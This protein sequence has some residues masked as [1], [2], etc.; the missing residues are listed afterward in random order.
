MSINLDQIES[1]SLAGKNA[2][3]KDAN[4]EKW[5]EKDIQLFGSGLGDRKKEAFYS[6]L[7]VL[8]SAGVDI[9]SAL[10]L[11]EEE[12]R[13]DRDKK[14][15]QA[16]G[17]SVMSGESLS[18]AIRSSGSFSDYEYF[19][20]RIGEESGRLPEVLQDLARYYNK[21]LA[22]RR[23]V[24]NAL[25]YPIIV[26]LTAVGAIVFML[27][28][29]VPMFEDIFQRFGG[30]L[31]ALTQLIIN[32]SNGAGKLGL[33]FLLV[34]TSVVAI[35]IFQ[36]KAV[37]YRSLSSTLVLRI[38][39][40][41][42][43]M[44][45]VFLA[46]TCQSLNLLIGAGLPLVEAL[47][48]VGKMVRFYPLEVALLHIREQIM[49]GDALHECM[50]RY[51]IFPKRLVSLVK[52]AEEVNQLDLIFGKMAEQYQGEVEHRTSLISSVLEPILIITIGLFVGIILI[53][54]YLP[55]FKL[56]DTIG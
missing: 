1:S 26:L 33:P 37:W 42:P 55:L 2:G 23:Q 56:G 21:K 25:S 47:E 10:E 11:V 29:I 41:G 4:A 17:Q 44:R 28:V 7:S 27:R 34:L 12:Q 6:E 30:D 15:F 18:E 36:R 54:M 16:I 22:Q 8:F 31:P 52:V 9:K 45:R 24:V 32:L 20:L 13:K 46:R 38:P 50:A 14:L 39:L 43:I 51:L 3:K 53:A 19:N 49:K 35:S 40:L 48:L 5:Y